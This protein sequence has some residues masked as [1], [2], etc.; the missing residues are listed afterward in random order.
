MSG[1]PHGAVIAFPRDLDA[2]LR[3]VSIKEKDSDPKLVMVDAVTTMSNLIRESTD[4]RLQSRTLRTALHE[5]MALFKV[6]LKGVREAIASITA[7]T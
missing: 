1:K 4:L 6:K 2:W 5:E 3:K 7:A